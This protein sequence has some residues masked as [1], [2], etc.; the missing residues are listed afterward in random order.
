MNKE[1]SLGNTDLDPNEAEGLLVNIT[2]QTELNTY[3]ARNIGR[4]TEWA[5]KSRKLKRE[6]FSVTGMKLLHQKMFCDIWS[7]A[8]E[9]RKTEKNI[10]IEPF[11]IQIQLEELCRNIEY[12]VKEKTEDIEAIAIEFHHKLTRIH[13][14]PNGNGRHARL[15]TDLLLFY[16]KKKE[17][18]WGGKELKN[19]KDYERKEYIKALKIADSTGD[20]SLLLAFAKKGRE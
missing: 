1:S 19:N 8:G 9:F 10:G 7:W 17:F 15:A 12:R 3:E 18:S 20:C 11:Q 16:H 5:K 6:F 13:P 4:A 14:F 2:K